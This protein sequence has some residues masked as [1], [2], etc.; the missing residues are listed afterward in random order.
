MKGLETEIKLL[1]RGTV[2]V[3]QEQ[4]L[5]DKLT[6]SY[7]Q[8]KPLRV[9]AGFDPTAPDLHLGHTVLLH[10]M[11]HFQ[12]LGHHVI[13][14]IGDFT[15]MIGD[16][17]GV[18]ETRRP[19]G[20]DAVVENA[21][22]YEEQVYKILDREK[23]TV[24]FN[25]QWMGQMKAEE[26][27][28]L[29]A[30]TS[31]ARMLERDDFRKRYQE[32]KP[33]SIHEFLYPLVQGYDSVALQADVELGGTDQKFNLLVGRDLQRAMGQ[34]PQVV[35]T[36]P[37]LEGIDGIKK[38]SKSAGNYVSLE[39]S[40]HEMFRKLM[41]IPD[42]VM[43]KYYELLS[44]RSLE[45]IKGFQ[46]GI[47]SGQLSPREIKKQLAYE[48][49]ARYHSESDAGGAGYAYEI[50]AKLLSSGD[51]GI[52]TRQDWAGVGDP[53]ELSANEWQNGRLWICKLMVKA[54]CAESHS[55]ARRLIRQ[56]AV[57]LNGVR[58]ED[59]EFEV[60]LSEAP[61][62]LNVGR[63]KFVKIVVRK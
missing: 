28:R 55:A 30:N 20:R 57:R 24:A 47:V 51:S 38:M 11:R 36:L 31:V 19:L 59:E 43:M 61:Y 18:S 39:D 12:E 32:Q 48:I 41:Q 46:E 29:S 34:S 22:T 3:I 52:M 2:E 63:N 49:V 25:S 5:R 6:R 54:S 50:G 60:P 62:L 7:E 45:E 1:L 13:F 16:P 58:V 14:L 27:I 56:G 10:K 23:T 17:T 15:G 40:P 35:I 9:K 8:K 33:I 4:E 44:E 53:V 21:K 42:G 26:L 37:L